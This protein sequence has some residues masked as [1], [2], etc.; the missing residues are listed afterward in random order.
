MTDK[1]NNEIM[2]AF[3][4]IDGMDNYEGYL[5]FIFDCLKVG[6]I[7]CMCFSDVIDSITE[8]IHGMD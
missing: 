2:E 6:L 1:N 7:Q 5:S 4:M 8:S 3:K